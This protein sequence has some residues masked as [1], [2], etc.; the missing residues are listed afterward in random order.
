MTHQTNHAPPNPPREQQP[1]DRE[2]Q[3]EFQRRDQLQDYGQPYTRMSSEPAQGA[4]QS[5]G[6]FTHPYS[7]GQG[8]LGYTTA[9]SGRPAPIDSPA[10]LSRPQRSPVHLTVERLDE[11]L[12]PLPLPPQT[13]PGAEP[14]S[15]L[16][17][18]ACLTLEDPRQHQAGQKRQAPTPEP[19]GQPAPRK[20]RPPPA[21]E[22]TGIPEQTE[23][24]PATG[25]QMRR[26]TPPF[27]ERTET[28]GQLSLDDYPPL[29]PSAQASKGTGPKSL[30]PQR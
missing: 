3:P 12:E 10:D 15:R 5:Y 18:L 13:G 22:G 26:R 20:R 9:G 25:L 4:P 29:P 30:A 17:Q 1:P 24:Q 6:S 19:Q 8:G 7:T 14:P 23:D 11:P 2:F 21:P 27:G 16:M 28:L